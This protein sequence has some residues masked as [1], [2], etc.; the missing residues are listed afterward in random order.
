MVVLFIW[1]FAESSIFPIPPDAFL[2]AMV[3]TSFEFGRSRL[4]SRQWALLHK[5]GIYWLWFYAWSVY[6]FSLFYYQSPAVLIDYVYYWGGLAAWGLRMAAWSK[7]RWRQAA[8]AS[9]A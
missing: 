5:S 7:K 8:A 3:L 4:T 2:I 6:W 9:P 1:A